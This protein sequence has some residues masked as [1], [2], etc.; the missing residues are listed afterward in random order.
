MKKTHR[1]IFAASFT[2]FVVFGFLAAI[3]AVVR[4]L[5]EG[6]NVPVLMY[7]G[8]ADDPQKDVWTVSIDEFDRHMRDL[9]A[10]GRKAVLPNQLA[11]AA[12]GLYL[13]P[14]K[15]VV[16]T[17]DDG[18]Q[19]NVTLAEPIMRKY[20]MKGI[21]Y[22]IM[23]HIEDSE[24]S[25]SQYRDRN[26]L[27]W[28]EVRKALEGGALV[29][30]SHSI[31]HTPNAK[32]QA[33]EVA[34]SHGI[35]KEKTG[36]RINAYCYPNGGAPDLL[37]EA[38]KKDH[39]FTT[40]MVCDDKVFAFSRKADL[41]RIPRVSV[42][43]GNHAFAVKT[44]SWSGGRLSVRI[45]N[46]GLPMPVRAMLRETG[47]GRVFLSDG[48]PARIGKGRSHSQVFSW[49][50]LPRDLATNALEIV[51]SEQNGLFTYG[52]PVRVPLP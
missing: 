14:R 25:R 41:F 44:P 16:I 11:L 8:F 26:N 40:A 35:F 19:D 10:S 49:D 2:I 39:L 13:L 48:D 32:R 47:T 9:K 34:P 29:F 46:A 28:P 33:L 1:R 6:R 42:Y 22:L 30:G 36:R 17:M 52:T 20:G 43:G 5:N 50:A 45:S 15:P 18:F 21:C 51:V 12:K 27:V 24:D 37:W 4:N 38:V 23:S 7:H 3:P 31:S